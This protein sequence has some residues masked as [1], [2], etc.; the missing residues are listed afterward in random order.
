ML[1]ANRC[2]FAAGRIIGLSL[3][4]GGPQPNFLSDNMF[5]FINSHNATQPS[6]FTPDEKFLK[7]NLI[8]KKLIQASTND[9]YVD[10]LTG[11]D[12][13][14]LEEIG[15]RGNPFKEKLEQRN[16]I[17][18]AY[19]YKK[20]IEPKIS[21][22]SQ[23][24]DGLNLSNLVESIRSNPDD[25]K[26]FFVKKEDSLNY[27]DFFSLL[28]A[29]FSLKGSNKYQSEVNT[30]QYF[31]DMIEEMFFTKDYGIKS[32]ELLQYIT[33]ASA[34][35]ALGFQKKISVKFVHGCTLN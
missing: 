25:F 1:L 10:I 20:N 12:N 35:P 6:T 16:E 9:E 23:L 30:Y 2:F 34:L 3:I 27:E 31:L 17:V 13:S 8:C 29:E 14:F 24:V 22:M 19:F 15:Y 28:E 5:S 18:R 33:G 11:E 26:G 7:N 32:I 4:Q 21:C